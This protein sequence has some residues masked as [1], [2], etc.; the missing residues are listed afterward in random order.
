M[1]H[2]EVAQKW[3]HRCYG[4][5]D[6][7]LARA[8]RK[9]AYELAATL[10]REP[11][12]AVVHSGLKRAAFPARRLAELARL[13]PT[14]DPRWQERDFGT[15]EGRT[16][17]AIWLET[18]NEMDRMLTDP[19]HYRPGGGERTAALAERSVAGWNALPLEGCVV[20]ITHGGPIAAV[21]GM[22]VGAAMSEMASFTIP[23]GTFVELPR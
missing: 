15:W 1:R 5:S 2:T 21:R 19:D 4:R 17:N 11:V 9:Q 18:R 14:V 6:V 20:V 23:K 12:T 3:V 10:A 13:E 16:W 22:L 8:G 7:G